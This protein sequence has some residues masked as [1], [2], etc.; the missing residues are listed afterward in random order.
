M[1]NPATAIASELAVLGLCLETPRA[2]K[3]SLAALSDDDFYLPQHRAIWQI[4]RAQTD[5]GVRVDAT[6]VMAAVAK[7]QAQREAL[8]TLA[9]TPPAGSLDFHLKAIENAA[10]HREL[11]Q[12]LMRIT[13]E[14]DNAA[15][16]DAIGVA[17]EGVE[18][19]RIVQRLR[20][21]EATEI[22]VLDVA[23]RVMR[24]EDMVIPG[25]LARGERVII[26]APEGY[27]KSTLLRQMAVATAA[28]IHPFTAARITPRRT[29]VIDAENPEDINTVEYQDMIQR[30]SDLHAAPTRGMAVIEECGPQNLLN[31]REAANLY[32][33]I[34]R[35]MPEMIIIGP[36]Y[37]LHE[38]D[39][40]D[41]R[42][43]RKLSAVLHKMTTINR[44]A[45]VVEAHTP[46]N[47][48]P[49]GQLLRPYGAS[50]W[51]R[52][53]DFGLCL[54]P[55]TVLKHGRAP[56]TNEQESL[57]I[58]ESLFSGWRGF[59][60]RRRWPTHLSAGSHLPWQVTPLSEPGPP[61]NHHEPDLVE[62]ARPAQARQSNPRCPIGAVQREP[63][64]VYV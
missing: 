51:K 54:H 16:E 27:G 49:G 3:D 22:D 10:I 43:A 23:A 29:L 50:L 64:E 60:G 2:L 6:S 53:P 41:E 37:Q 48:G 11:T 38:E 40:A 59:G 42:Y 33:L 24:P 5:E 20:R 34:E 31:P 63:R 18:R 4:I 44:S 58:K 57:R 15:H 56:T 36:I 9:T 14:A 17:E 30:L 26:T 12:S 7:H 55:V 21:P 28:G 13:Q 46:H 19:L 62:P 52:W 47:D 25:I 32:A 61:V 8:V 35:V 45:L 1:R 39:P